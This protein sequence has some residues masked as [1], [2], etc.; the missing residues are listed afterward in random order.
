MS[1]SVKRISFCIVIAIIVSLDL[2][3]SWKIGNFVDDFEDPT[4][5]HF[6]YSTAW[7]TFNNSE[8]RKADSP[9]RVLFYLVNGNFNNAVIEFEPHQYVWDF[10]VEEFND[11]SCATIK[12]KDEAGK[13]YSFY[14]ENTKYSHS[15]NYVTGKDAMKIAKLFRDNKT[16]KIYI[17]IESYTFNYV[18]DCSDFETLYKDYVPSFDLRKNEWDLEQLNERGF[19]LASIFLDSTDSA[20]GISLKFA[21]YPLSDKTPNF[22]WEVYY[23]DP[24]IDEF[25]SIGPEKVDKLVFSVNDNVY[26]YP[27]GKGYDSGVISNEF[28]Y[29]TWSRLYKILSFGEELTIDV[30]IT[31]GDIV[32]FKTSASEFLKYTK[33]PYDFL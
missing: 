16:V 26:V 4:G 6:L 28:N 2:F 12:I 30:Y 3:A 19:C 17:S 10:S 1:R 7:G 5:E 15:W 11:N 33:Y 21:G 23:K 31:S 14:T 18:L 22:G 8:T 32:S 25:T 24:E 29:F 20:Y 9:V 27:T 13:V